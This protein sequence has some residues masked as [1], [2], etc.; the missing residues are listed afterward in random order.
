[1]LNSI[2]NKSRNTSPSQAQTIKSKSSSPN[3]INN[4]SAAISQAIP[5]LD[6][7]QLL[8]QQIQQQSLNM[9]APDKSQVYKSSRINHPSNSTSNSKNSSPKTNQEETM[10]SHTSTRVKK[11]KNMPKP[12]V[13]STTMTRRR[14]SLISVNS[15]DSRESQKRRI[16]KNRTQRRKAHINCPYPIDDMFNINSS[17]EIDDEADTSGFPDGFEQVT[18]ENVSREMGPGDLAHKRQVSEPDLSRNQRIMERQRL[19]NLSNSIVTT[20]S[21]NQ[22]RIQ[23][24]KKGKRIVKPKSRIELTQQDQFQDAQEEISQ[25]PSQP[26]INQESQSQL[27]QEVTPESHIPLH[28]QPNLQ[29][30]DQE[31]SSELRQSPSQLP[32]IIHEE[33]VTTRTQAVACIL[34]RTGSTARNSRRS[35]R[36]RELRQSEDMNLRRGYDYQRIMLERS[37]QNRENI[38]EVP[39]DSNITESRQRSLNSL[40]GTPNTSPPQRIPNKQNSRISPPISQPTTTNESPIQS[41]SIQR[42]SPIHATTNIPQSQSPI[43]STTPSPPTSNTNIPRQLNPTTPENTV[44]RSDELR[45][46]IISRLNQRIDPTLIDSEIPPPLDEY[47]TP[48]HSSPPYREHLHKKTDLISFDP[49]YSIP[50]LRLNKKLI[51]NSNSLNKVIKKL[52]KLNC[53]PTEI[54]IWDLEKIDDHEFHVIL[55]ELL[56][57]YEIQQ[58]Q[59]REEREANELQRAIALSIAEQTQRDQ[60]MELF[61]GFRYN[62]PRNVENEENYQDSSGDEFIDVDDV[63]NWSSQPSSVM[64]TI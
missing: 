37:L 13:A 14:N 12:R 57:T 55:P 11:G 53:I 27:Q 8:S 4:S 40:T 17:F 21:S 31:T 48:D 62:Q 20:T 51:K 58:R 47:K 64:L 49:R 28:L 16:N 19:R 33:E 9:E 10:A 7:I 35:R 36:A 1:M 26:E 63:V 6:Q 32:D 42:Q 44:N 38:E 23:P 50:I 41:S 2:F 29:I 54:N 25:P 34:E 43:Q 61:R 45:S 59:A 46:A 60:R 18:P 39:R 22:S 24:Y 3:S 5:N 15:R 56:A 52:I 30:L